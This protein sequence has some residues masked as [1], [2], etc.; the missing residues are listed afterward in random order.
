MVGEGVGYDS[1]DWL[2]K[3]KYGSS[4]NRENVIERETKTH[5]VACHFYLASF[6]SISL[7]APIP[8]PTTNTSTQAACN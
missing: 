7:A 5:P 1:K 2:N 8:V 3:I 4:T 6:K